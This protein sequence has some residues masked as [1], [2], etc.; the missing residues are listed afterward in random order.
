M[1]CCVCVY[2][3]HILIILLLLLQDIDKLVN[4]FIEGLYTKLCFHVIMYIVLLTNLSIS[5]LENIYH[6]ILVYYLFQT[7]LTL[8]MYIYCDYGDQ[9]ST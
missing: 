9:F 8:Y 6:L 7:Y 4:K 2:D 3:F 5:L 1:H